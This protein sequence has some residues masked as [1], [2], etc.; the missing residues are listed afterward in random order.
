MLSHI[1]LTLAT[2]SLAAADAQ[3]IK[4]LLSP[5]SPVYV[6][7][8]AVCESPCRVAYTPVWELHICTWPQRGRHDRRVSSGDY[9][10]YVVVTCPFACAMVHAYTCRVQ[11]A[12][13]KIDWSSCKISFVN[14]ELHTDLPGCNRSRTP[15]KAVGALA[16]D[17]LG[18]FVQSINCFQLSNAAHWQYM[19]AAAETGI[20]SGS[21]V[22]ICTWKNIQGLALP[23][24]LG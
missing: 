2:V 3:L 11:S 22:Y 21:P 1:P 14:E 24:H 7:Y 20:M 5:A 23:E 16:Q 13:S 10:A 4:H 18:A 9:D 6:T 12:T 15:Y 19:S 8:T 17:G